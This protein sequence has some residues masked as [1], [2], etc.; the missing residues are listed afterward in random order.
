MSRTKVKQALRALAQ[1]CNNSN[2]LAY[3]GQYGRTISE[4]EAKLKAKVE[5]LPIEFEDAD[6]SKDL[7]PSD[8][9][10]ALG[11]AAIPCDF[12]NNI[13]MLTKGRP[14]KLPTERV[15]QWSKHRPTH[16]RTCPL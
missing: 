11:L 9:Q 7:R 14:R 2:A 16:F 4:V 10:R 5:L 12:S 6:K 1:D 13:V 8:L 15:G 3:L